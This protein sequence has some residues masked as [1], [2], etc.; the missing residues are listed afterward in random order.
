VRYGNKVISMVLV[1]EIKMK[2]DF[3]RVEILTEE[4]S[5]AEVLKVILP[6][7]LPDQ[8]ILNQNYFI[9]PHEGKSD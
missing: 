5:M 7:I 3:V 1:S 8:W 4:S 9:R 6:K 2:R